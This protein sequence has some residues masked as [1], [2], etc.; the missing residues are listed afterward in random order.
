MLG[1]IDKVSILGKLKQLVFD[2]TA[3]AILVR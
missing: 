3:L 1:K 2:K